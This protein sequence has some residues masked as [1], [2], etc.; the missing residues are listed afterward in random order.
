MSSSVNVT[1]MTSSYPS[2]IADS[3]NW[4]ILQRIAYPVEAIALR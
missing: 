1:S 4:D 3:T 2:V